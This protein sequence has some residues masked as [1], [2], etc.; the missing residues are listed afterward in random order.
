MRA[1]PTCST[2]RHGLPGGLAGAILALLLVLAVGMTL[3]ACATVPD[4]GQTASE[5]RLKELHVQ[6]GVGYMREGQYER[7]MDRLQ[8]ALALDPGYPDAHNA[9]ALLYEQIG[10]HADAERHFLEAIRLDPKYSTAHTNYGSFLCSQGRPREGEEQFLVAVSNPLYD[11]ADLAYTNAGLCML[12]HGTA[13]EAEEYLRR[14]LQENPRMP[15][16]LLGMA[17]LSFEAGRALAARG[18]LQRYAEV[19]PATPASLLLGYRVETALGD[20]DAAAGYALRLRAR[21]PDSLEVR[22]LDELSDT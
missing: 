22:T 18:Y 1:S 7:A 3:S 21:F 13:A 5:D 17:R 8:R 16:A 19:G 6:L 4:G 20:L 10:E 9:I 11:R 2:L 14:A 12:R 15:V